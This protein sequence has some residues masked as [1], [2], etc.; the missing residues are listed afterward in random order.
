MDLAAN[1]TP[2][3]NTDLSPVDFTPTLPFS[4]NAHMTVD[5]VDQIKT[6]TDTE[7]MRMRILLIQK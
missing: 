1:S 4:D 7:P 5:F 3:V 2:T 6:T